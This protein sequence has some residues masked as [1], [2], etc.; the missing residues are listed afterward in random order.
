MTPTA[1][2][3]SHDDADAIL[4]T[5]ARWRAEGR[6][7]ALATVVATWGSSP[8]PA[9]SQLA[10]DDAGEFVGSVSGGCVE[11]AVISE[12]RAILK[13]APA[14]LLAFGVSDEQAWDVGL[15]CGG[16]V[17]IFVHSLAGQD[18]LLGTL[19]R[20][21]AT[22]KPAVIA[23]DLADGRSTLFAEG[24]AAGDVALRTALV[25]EAARA[26]AE[27]RS[28]V[29]DRDG[30]RCF[31]RVFAQPPRL[32]LVGAVHIAQALIPMAAAAGY[33][34]T[35]I[36]PRRAFAAETRFPNVAMSHEWP[37]SALA[38]FAPDRRSAVI[39]LTHDPKLDDPA[40]AAALRSDAFYVGAL[41]SRK[42]HAARL[43]RLRE[44]GFGDAELGRIRAPVGLAIGAVSPAEIA[45]SI[46][47]ELT[48]A[49]RGA[50]PLAP[51]RQEP[52]E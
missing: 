3:F 11:S 33:D 7:V 21:R 37:E 22:R 40:L 35:V 15:A 45:V 31:L 26:Q 12:A 25:A 18:E 4:G 9:G 27:D 32:A 49:L 23:I 51:V 34:I 38:A 6:R 50:A 16:K 39:A 43:T 14:R 28:R 48:Q 1:T 52:K 42:T 8:R 17:E 5:A 29:V 30:R 41:G 20:V 19:R 47:A 44:Q 24:E 46:L 2:P 13:G 10:A 36:D